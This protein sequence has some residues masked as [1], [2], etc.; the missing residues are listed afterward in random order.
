MGMQQ[1]AI[2]P[3]L[4]EPYPIMEVYATEIRRVRETN[5]MV[6]L[7]FCRRHAEPGREVERVIVARIVMSRTDYHSMVRKMVGAPMVMS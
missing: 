5:E 6:S 3:P 2:C 7:T 1:Q 4:V